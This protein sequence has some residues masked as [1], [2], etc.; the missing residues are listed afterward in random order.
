MAGLGYIGC[1]MKKRSKREYAMD[2]T[3]LN[4]EIM[5]L[6]IEVRRLTYRNAAFMRQIKALKKRSNTCERT[7]VDG[8]ASV[9]DHRDSPGDA[10]AAVEIWRKD[11]TAKCSQSKC[12]KAAPVVRQVAR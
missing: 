5:F 8:Q 9:R 12:G 3:A 4:K 10:Q 7:T 1:A 6:R 2:I 11:W